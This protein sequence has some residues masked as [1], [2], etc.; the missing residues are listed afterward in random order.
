MAENVVQEVSKAPVPQPKLLNSY[1]FSKELCQM[2]FIQSSFDIDGGF[3]PRP[4]LEVF[5][6]KF[7]GH[8]NQSHRF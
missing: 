4:K 7:L 2:Q 5:E 1:A 8:K 6:S 3:I